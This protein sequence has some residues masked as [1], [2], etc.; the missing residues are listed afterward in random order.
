MICD[1]TIY[2]AFANPKLEKDFEKLKEGT[3]EDKQLSY[4]IQRAIIDL[5][6][7]PMY[8]VKIPKKLWPKGYIKNYK[9][10]NLWKYD[11]PNGWRLIYSIF[12][13]KLMIINLIL[14]WF[15]HKDYERIIRY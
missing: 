7:G 3:Y 2:V 4:F 15:P 11:L 9:I 6:K 14:E 12:E 10:N 1:K 5:K 13:D 8:G